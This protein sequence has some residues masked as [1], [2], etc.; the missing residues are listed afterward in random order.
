MP[1]LRRNKKHGSVET[2]LLLSGLPCVSQCK[3]ERANSATIS[4]LAAVQLQFKGTATYTGNEWGAYM[5]CS[6]LTESTK[7][8]AVFNKTVLSRVI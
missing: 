6:T 2:L 7:K 4:L 3:D 5:P 8:H 1:L